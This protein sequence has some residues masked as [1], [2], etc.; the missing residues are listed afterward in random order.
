MLPVKGETTRKRGEGR[1]EREDGRG[2]KRERLMNTIVNGDG[3][4]QWS[5]LREVLSGHVFW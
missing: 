4:S 3:P 1:G 5:R 2:R